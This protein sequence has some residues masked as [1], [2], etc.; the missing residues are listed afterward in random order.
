MLIIEIEPLQDYRSLTGSYMGKFYSSE[1]ELFLNTT[2][3]GTAHSASG[4]DIKVLIKTISTSICICAIQLAFFCFFRPI[5]KNLYQPRSY[6]VSANERMTPISDGMLDWIKPTIQIPT[7]FYLSMGLDAYFF[8]RFLSILLLYF[9]FIGTLNVII[10]IPV[11]WTGNDERYSAHGLDKLSLSNIANSKVHRL[12]FH[13]IMGLIT[14]VIFHISLIYELDSIIKIRNKYFETIYDNSVI[15]KSVLISNVPEDLLNENAIVDLFSVIPGGVNSVWFT[16]ETSR[17]HYYVKQAKDTLDLLEKSQLDYIKRYI[18]QS[19]SKDYPQKYH[20]YNESLET[21]FYPPIYIH[22]YFIPFVKRYI[23]MKLPGILRLFVWEQKQSKLNWSIQKLNELHRSIKHEQD[24][25]VNGKQLKY[26]K[27]F[28]QFNS[29]IGT[30]I[31]HQCLLEKSQGKFDK[32]LIGVNPKDIVWEG[33]TSQNTIVTLFQRYCVTVVFSIIIILYIVPVSLIGLVFQVNFLTKIIPFFN[34]IY[35]FPEGIRDIISCFLPSILLTILMTTM[36][37]VFRF[38]AQ[39]RGYVT[40]AELE[41]SVQKWYFTFLFIQQFMVVT[42]L[43]SMVQ[44]IKQVIDQPT[45]IPVLLAINLPKAATFFFQFMSLK[46]FSF[47]GSNFMK[48]ESFIKERTFYKLQS[49]TPRQT[50]H[51][52]IT[53]PILRL[54]TSYPIYSVYACIGIIYTILSPMI[55]VFIVFLLSLTLLYYKYAFKYIYHH[56]N[57]SETYGALYPN[58]LFQLYTGIYFLEGCLIGIFFLLKDSVGNHPLRVHGWIMC[59][60]SMAT[61]FAHLAIYNRYYKFFTLQPILNRLRNQSNKKSVSSVHSNTED[62]NHHK[63]LYLHPDFTY[64]YPKLWLPDDPLHIAQDKIEF[65]ESK[66]DFMKGGTTKGALI[67]QRLKNWYCIVTQ[68][69]PDF[70]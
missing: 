64:E 30:Y 42:I 1:F 52:L 20:L 37:S 29:Q 27:V 21:R 53:L 47:C 54:G 56:I 9:I 26:N 24:L 7:N 58:A 31:T 44:L 22:P 61:L 39:F 15:A 3:N 65:L 23:F 16:Y 55:S 68:E 70:K 49:F 41:I 51:R 33:L 6:Y 60:V 13:F 2:I 14:I 38:L 4:T 35:K 18:H 69:P 25:L 50:F 11:N 5:M 28:I 8:I 19:Q 66:L 36:I 46:A 48:V 40:G 10:L 67:K 17:I 63:Q 45:S 34:W 43:S 62:I 57:K 12:N 32:T 59:L